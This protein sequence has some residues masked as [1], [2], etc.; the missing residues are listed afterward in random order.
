MCIGHGAF[1]F[2]RRGCKYF[3]EIVQV[4]KVYQYCLRTVFS[5]T[6]SPYETVTVHLTFFS[7]KNQT[8][9]IFSQKNFSCNCV[10]LSLFLPPPLPHNNITGA[11]ILSG[12]LLDNS[13]TVFFLFYRRVIY[14]HMHSHFLMNMFYHCHLLVP[15]PEFLFGSVA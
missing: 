5:G 6:S 12:I 4:K 11:N 1:T 9:M 13:V 8:K 10:V 3:R 7:Q 14:F 2:L 15:K